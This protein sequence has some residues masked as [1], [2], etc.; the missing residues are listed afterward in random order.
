MPGSLEDRK[1]EEPCT[2]VGYENASGSEIFP[3]LSA[4]GLG[5][6]VVFLTNP[7]VES[8]ERREYVILSFKW[9]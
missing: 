9:F 3:L 4:L 5:L 2:S 8:R 7:S 1:S 6:Y